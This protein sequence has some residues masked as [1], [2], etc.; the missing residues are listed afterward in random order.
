MRIEPL[1]EAA[2]VD[3]PLAAV[4]ARADLRGTGLDLP[5][6]NLFPAKGRY[7]WRDMERQA[8]AL[9]LPFRKP[10]PFQQ[11]ALLAARVALFGAR[12]SLGADLLEGGLPGRVQRGARHRR[13]RRH[14]GDRRASWA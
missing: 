4:P 13:A 7:M 9:R 8:A 10:D 3:M 11:N 14:P 12:P 5:A 6:F 1:A 2:G